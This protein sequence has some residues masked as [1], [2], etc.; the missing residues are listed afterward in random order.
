MPFSQLRTS[1]NKRTIHRKTRSVVRIV[2]I[3]PEHNWK[4]S[5]SKR[6]SS[7]TWNPEMVGEVMYYIFNNRNKLQSIQCSRRFCMAF[8]AAGFLCDLTKNILVLKTTVRTY[9]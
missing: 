6:T 3:L 4:M 9:Y 7:T 5:T 2:Y 1:L 8:L